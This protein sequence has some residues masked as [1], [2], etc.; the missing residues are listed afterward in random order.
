MEQNNQE[1]RKH[2]SFMEKAFIDA[3]TSYGSKNSSNQNN[4]RFE[5]GREPNHSVPKTAKRPNLA[6]YNDEFDGA[7]IDTDIQQSD[8]DSGNTTE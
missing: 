2:N 1:E 4:S 3:N 8:I 7:R 5:V 6:E